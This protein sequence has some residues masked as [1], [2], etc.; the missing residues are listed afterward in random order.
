MSVGDSVPTH[1]TW[2]IYARH[3]GSSRVRDAITLSRETVAK[4]ALCKFALEARDDASGNQSYP[5]RR[6]QSRAWKENFADEPTSGTR[7][8]PMRGDNV[9]HR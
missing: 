5:G 2:A 3:L 8:V 1:M 4:G 9:Q 7:R 6:V